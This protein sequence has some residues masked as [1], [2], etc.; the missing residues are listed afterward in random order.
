ML[1]GRIADFRGQGDCGSFDSLWP[2]TS[3]IESWVRVGGLF[4]QIVAGPSGSGLSFG[5]IPPLAQWWESTKPR[6]KSG[7]IL[8]IESGAMREYPPCSVPNAARKFRMGR[9][10]VQGAVVR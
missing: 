2:S 9:A 1:G 3:S 8:V 4:I 6:R 10:F 5:A 7:E